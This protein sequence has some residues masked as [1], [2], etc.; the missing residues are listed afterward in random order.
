MYNFVSNYPY[1][2]K[3]ILDALLVFVYTSVKLPQGRFQQIDSDNIC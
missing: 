1:Y 2:I 3:K